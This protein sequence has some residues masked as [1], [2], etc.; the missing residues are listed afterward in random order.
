MMSFLGNFTKKFVQH[1]GYVLILLTGMS[2]LSSA[3]AFADDA[4]ERAE[5]IKIA[6]LFHFSQFTEWDVK[7][8][9]FTYCVY[10]D[11]HFSQLLK[12]AYTGKTLGDLQ[13]DVQQVNAQSNFEPCQLV[14]FP[15]K[16]PSEI[17]AQLRKKPILTVSEQKNILE[18]SIIYLFEDNQ[19]IR[20]FINNAAAISVG[21]KINSQLLSLS[22]EPQP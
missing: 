21:L 9:V 4:Q 11:T 1:I 15:T 16:T 20:F 13:V 14:Y 6:Y 2:S 8:R 10:E 3:F 5:K 17:L 18:Q 7:P 12:Q 22:R 19:K